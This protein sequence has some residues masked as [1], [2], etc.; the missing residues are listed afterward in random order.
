MKTAITEV[1]DIIEMEHNNGVEISK[2][3]LWKMLLEAKEKERQQIINAHEAGQDV[4]IMDSD[5][6]D[7]R[8]Y[9]YNNF[10]Q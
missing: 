10:E 2:K 6:T 1:M 7:S 3:V 8:Q 4:L 9:Y 5:F